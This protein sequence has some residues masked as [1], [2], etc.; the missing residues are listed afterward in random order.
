MKSPK[1]LIC[2]NCGNEDQADFAPGENGKP[3]C[4]ACGWSRVFTRT[5]HEKVLKREAE[6]KEKT[7][8]LKNDINR[9]T[10]VE[11]W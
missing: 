8:R 2:E 11:E 6:E 1:D 5:E 3:I 7:E 4:G 9:A 10:D